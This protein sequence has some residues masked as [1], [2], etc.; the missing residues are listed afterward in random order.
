MYVS[1]MSVIEARL[2]L[3]LFIVHVI[4]SRGSPLDVVA[5]E[6]KRRKKRRAP[7]AGRR[8]RNDYTL[9][10]DPQ[11]AVRCMYTYVCFMH[12]SGNK[13]P[14][15]MAIRNKGQTRRAAHGRG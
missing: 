7:G 3:A 1:H 14:L 12:A 4:Y 11:R 6:G 8:V 2:L 15:A 5:C 13:G 9:I 10:F